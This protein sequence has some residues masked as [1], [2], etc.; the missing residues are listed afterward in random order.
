MSQYFCQYSVYNNSAFTVFC[1]VDP[2]TYTSNEPER[3]EKKHTTLICKGKLRSFLFHYYFFFLCIDLFFFVPF[4]TYK[5]FFK[6]CHHAGCSFGEVAHA[7]DPCGYYERQAKDGVD[8]DRAG[9]PPDSTVQS[10]N[11]KTFRNGLARTRRTKV[12][13]LC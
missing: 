6:V 8:R 1:E 2:Q 12:R 13:T 3:S 9:P 4:S 7:G 5:S 11:H 10:P